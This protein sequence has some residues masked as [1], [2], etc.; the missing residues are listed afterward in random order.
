MEFVNSWAET[1]CGTTSSPTGDIT[2]TA[3][4]YNT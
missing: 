1:A 4:L 2:S 3:V